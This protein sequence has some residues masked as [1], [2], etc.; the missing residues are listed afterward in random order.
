MQG[1]HLP[2]PILDDKNTKMIHESP[3]LSS[4]GN[5]NGS[6]SGSGNGNGIC[7]GNGDGNG[8]GNGNGDGNGNGMFG[9]SNLSF[10][11]LLLHELLQDQPYVFCSGYG[12]NPHFCKS[13]SQRW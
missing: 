11:A 10:G 7:N 4:L 13:V 6:S 2:P 1:F 9:G 5:G 8:N 12:W 3:P